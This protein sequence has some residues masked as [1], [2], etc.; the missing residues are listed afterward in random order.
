MSNLSVRS[1][2]GKDNTPV[3]FPT[4]IVIGSGASGGIND[5]GVAG[6]PGFGVGV[7]PIPNLSGF[8]GM[9][10]YQNPMSDNY[11]N[12]QY[13]DGS[14]MVWIPA[15]FYKYGTGS[16]GLNV[17]VVDIKPLHHFADV[18]TANASGYAMHRAFYDN[19]ALQQGFFFDKYLAS[20]N[21]NT[22]CR[23]VKNGVPISLTTTAGYTVSNGMVTTEATCTGILA[24]S[25]LLARSRGIGVFNVP[26]VF[27]YNAIA[28]LALAHAQNSTNTTYCAW[29]HATNNFPKGCN[30]NTLSDVNDDSIVYQ[31]AGDSADLMKPKTGSANFFAKTTHNGQNCGIADVNGVMW[32]PALGI[33]NPGTTSTDNTQITNGNAYVLKQSVKLASL[34]HGWNGATDAW[35]ALANITSLYDLHTG[36][37]P[38]G[39]DIDWVRFGNGSNQVFSESTSGINWLRTACGVQ[40]D[41]NATSSS[42]TNLFGVDG[43]YRYN[44]SNMFVH[45]S[46]NWGYGTNAGVFYR[47]WIDVRSSDRATCGFRAAAF[48][49]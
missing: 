12:Y 46:G 21:G 37:L 19:G 28:L 25:I 8:V 18:A 9:V 33:T 41:T 31:S 24:D 34:T 30:N 1:I 14:V 48:G 38:W 6:Q 16:N 13:Q 4:G 17:N 5:I 27:M 40:R 36:I 10:G 42:G 23:S 11:G 44:R 2:T 26:T 22:S 49:S 45:C 20:K 29:Y 43:C 3:L 47:G 39:S 35:Q 15:F 32:Q 7:C